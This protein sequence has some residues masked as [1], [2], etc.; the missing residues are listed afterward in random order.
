[1]F[2]H[3][4][5]TK[6]TRRLEARLTPEVHELLQRAAN[7]EGRTLSVFVISA[8]QEAAG[9][10]IQQREIIQLSRD[11]QKRFADALLTAALP[12][13]MKRAAAAQRSLIQPP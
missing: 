10:V 8:A 4:D 12:R 7:L 5:A 11:D 1:M 3:G 6:K 9:K 13:S 2:E